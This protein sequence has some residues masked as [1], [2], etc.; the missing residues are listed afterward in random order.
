[1]NHG[2]NVDKNTA[3]RMKNALVASQ[4]AQNPAFKEYWKKVFDQLFL[5]I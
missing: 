4:R 2:M 3:R 1:M 5:G